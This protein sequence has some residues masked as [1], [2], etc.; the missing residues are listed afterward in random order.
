MT[1]YFNGRYPLTVGT[2]TFADRRRPLCR[3]SSLADWGHGVMVYI[4]V[5][6]LLCYKRWMIERC[7]F[8]D[9]IRNNCMCNSGVSFEVSLLNYVLDKPYYVCGSVRWSSLPSS[10]CSMHYSLQC[11]AFTFVICHMSF[12]FILMKFIPNTE[13]RV[14]NFQKQCSYIVLILYCI[15]CELILK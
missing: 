8:C 13:L 15:Q 7:L 5:G 9:L 12:N 3:Y 6:F 1:G 10:D 14:C 2:T 11:A 4:I